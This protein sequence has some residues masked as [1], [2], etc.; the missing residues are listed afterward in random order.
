LI[1]QIF[2]IRQLAEKYF[3]KNRILYNNFIDFKQAFDSVWQQGLWAVLRNF[4]VPEEL[5]ELLEDLYSKSMSAVRIDGE[6]TKWFRVTMGVRQGCGLSPYLFNLILEAVMNLAL[7]DTEIGGNIN[8]K[9]INNLRFA[10]DIDL[11]AEEKHQLQE[12]TDR[13]QNSSKRFGLKIK[14]EK[15]KTMTIGKIPEK[16]EVKIEGETLEQVTEFAYL[17]GLITEDAQCTKDIRRRIILV[18]PQRCLEN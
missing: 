15:M 5:V 18:W 3:D 6:L 16:M 8:G 2:I 13:V 4:G 11:I 7:K 17:G 10:D 14:G 1:D 9:M 12:L